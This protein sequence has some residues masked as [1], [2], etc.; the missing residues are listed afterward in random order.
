MMERDDTI[1]S[2]RERALLLE[3]REAYR[4]QDC[5]GA[6]NAFSHALRINPASQAEQWL[7]MTR[8]IVEFHDKEIYNP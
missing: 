1:I 7:Q 4:R 5:Q 2:A 6:I 3:G 8:A